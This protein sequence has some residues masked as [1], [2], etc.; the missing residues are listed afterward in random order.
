M[1]Q[2]PPPPLPSCPFVE[3]EWRRG[4]G[5]GGITHHLEKRRER[6]LSFPFP[7]ARACQHPPPPPPSVALITTHSLFLPCLH[8][9]LFASPPR[10]PIAIIQ[11]E[12]GA[13][14][15]NCPGEDSFVT[16]SAR[17]RKEI[18]RS[19]LI[20]DTAVQARPTSPPWESPDELILCMHIREANTLY[21]TPYFPSPAF[22]N[23]R[24]Q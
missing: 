17:A 1:Y 23:A 7:S 13:R 4:E 16:S 18:R 15:T 2:A 22:N 20:G 5:G 10:L 3:S 9:S 6:S 14:G 8:Q 11:R 12:G 24:R 19:I 21:L